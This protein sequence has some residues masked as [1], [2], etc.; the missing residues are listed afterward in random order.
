MSLLCEGLRQPTCRLQKL[1][2]DSCGLTAKACEDISSTLGVNQTLTE[3]YLTNNALRNTGVRLLCK[4]LS[5]PG[6]KLRVFW[7]FGMDLNKMTH[8][9][10]AALRLTKPYLDIG[11]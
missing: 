5:H 7:L 1:W 2:L 10:L 11:C 8:G 3:L 6:C 4:R 9:S